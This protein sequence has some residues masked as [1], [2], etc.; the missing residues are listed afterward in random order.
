MSSRISIDELTERL[1]DILDQVRERGERFVVERDG[2]ALATLAPPDIELG[3][4]QSFQELAARLAELP[5]PDDE[6]ADDLEAVQAEMNRQPLKI[7]E[8]PS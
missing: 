6:F 7:P 4:A 5:W 8:W 3:K 1:P 2:V